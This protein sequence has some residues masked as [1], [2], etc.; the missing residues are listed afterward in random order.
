[1]IILAWCASPSAQI[2][3]EEFGKNR[4]QYHHNFDNWWMYESENFITYWYGK[5][6]RIGS[7]AMQIAEVDYD[8][9]RNVIEHRIN[10]KIEIIV[11]VDLTDLKQSNLGSEEEFTTVAGK[12]KIVGRKI[13]VHF[14]G[15]HPRLRQQIREGVAA[16]L[17]DAMLYGSNLQE[18]VQNAVLLN[19]PEWFRDGLI[20]YLGSSW[21]AEINASLKKVILEEGRDESFED[22][23]AEYP[24]IV[25]H[26][27]WYFLSETYGRSSIANLLYLT[28]INRD[29]EHA[30]LYVLGVEPSRL[31]EDW[32]SFYSDLFTEDMSGDEEGDMFKIRDNRKLTKIKFNPKSDQYAYVTNQLGKNRVYLAKEGKS[33][34]IFKNGYCNLVQD[35][36]YN[37]PIIEW[38]NDGRYLFIVYEKRDVLY[39]QRLDTR[40]GT[41]EEQSIPFEIE[42]I[43]DISPINRDEFIFAGTD[44]GYSDLFKYFVKTR[45][46]EK[47]TD[48]YHDDLEVEYFND[49]QNEGIIFLS[50]RL[51]EA[52]IPR[53]YID[54]ILP[55][56]NPDIFFLD[57]NN[58]QSPLYRLS[59]NTVSD[60]RELKLLPGGR[61][62]FLSDKS[63][64][65]SRRILD[66]NA[67]FREIELGMYLDFGFDGLLESQYTDNILLFDYDPNSRRVLD[68]F[69]TQ[70]KIIS[71]SRPLNSNLIKDTMLLPSPHIVKEDKV[72]EVDSAQIEYALDYDNFFLSEFDNPEPE[73]KTKPKASHDWEEDVTAKYQYDQSHH[74]KV[75]K[76]VYSQAIASRLRFRLDHFNTSLDNSLLFGGL[77][78]YAGT[79]QGFENPPLGILLKSNF[80]DI[81]EDY[82]IDAGARITTSFTGSEYFILLKDKKRRIDKHYAVYR[83]SL[84]HDVREGPYANRRARTLTFIG[85]FQAR[86]PIDVYQS[87]RG[88]ATFRNDKFNILAVNRQTLD[89]PSLDEQRLG[90]KLEYVFDNTIE[91]DIN[92]R[93]GLRAKGYT[94]V[95]KRFAFDFDPF[96]LDGSE[97]FMTVVGLDV[98]YYQ[99]ILKHSVFAVRLN[100]ATSLGSEKI[101]FYTGGMNNWLFPVFDNSTPGPTEDN[102][103]YQTIATNLRGFN[104]NVRN[105]SSHLLVN[106]ELRLPIMKYLSK[107]RIKFTPLQQLQFSAFFDLGLA[108][109]GSS[110]FGG[111]DPSNSVVLQ[112]PSVTLDVNFFRDPLIMG[113]G[114]GVRTSLFGYYLK[115]DYAWGIET[116]TVQDPIYYLSI[117]TD[118]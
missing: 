35:P 84:K 83:K 11:Y 48:D 101:L 34:M 97:G 69:E 77:D 91:L 59:D 45:Q 80:K 46:F 94:E 60:K 76:Y 114:W 112:N 96:K 63:G 21:D 14:D 55:L 81:F 39:L 86:Y 68:L 9:I 23:S 15:S 8:E 27:F 88:S 78:T 116:R 36:D 108:W 107:R 42:R 105:G 117:G 103:A 33:K 64:V 72:E 87:I 22:L 100:G 75:P 82:E 7:A 28:R 98:R 2:L 12:T 43:Y 66:L 67:S 10:E 56:A 52:L 102:F 89:A 20:S 6:R 85:M 41:T 73:V 115:F 110:P 44:N 1:M 38:S 62:A 106:S 90:L 47:L 30:F 61:L 18:I 95:V 71:E 4:V 13:F 31:E 29:L 40:T 92:L 25:G 32:R 111:D 58:S 113:Y 37:Y 17:I 99:P 74:G 93:N 19:V 70:D 57:F 3:D 51:D 65:W 50:N 53:D 24:A 54:T 104:Y 109:S 49:G 16:I 26:S 5:G 79:K 118:F